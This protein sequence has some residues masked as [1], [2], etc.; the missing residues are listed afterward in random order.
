MRDG[1]GF[2]VPCAPNEAGEAIARIT[3]EPSGI[4]SRFEGYTDEGASQKKMLSNVF[5]DGDA[6]FR[7]GD[8]M[9]Q[10]EN[11]YFYF[12]DRLGDSFRWKGENVATTEVSEAINSFPG[13]M[14]SNV[15]GVAIPGCDGRAG[16]AALVAGNEL[17]L[18]ELRAHL[19]DRLPHYARPLFLRIR[20]QM[21]TTVTFKY[22]KTDLILDGYDPGRTSD[23]LYF[24]HPENGWII[25]LDEVLFQRIQ[26]GQIR[27]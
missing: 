16:M 6:W 15:Y 3:K 14:E 27:L 8:L 19:I 23:A 21:A 17:N 7:T 4:T 9:R 22:S 25:R 13:I 1:K 26:S 10:D 20:P 11:G 12:L 2:C 18:G 5:E 24:N